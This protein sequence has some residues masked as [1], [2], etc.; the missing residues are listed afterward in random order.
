MNQTVPAAKIL[1]MPT[2]SNAGDS[3]APAGSPV[4]STEGNLAKAVAFLHASASTESQPVA[5]P[6]S[7]LRVVITPQT[8]FYRKYTEA[9]LRRYGAMALQKGR[10]PSLLGRELFRGKVTSYR[11]HGF[12]DVIIFVADVERCLKLLSPEQQ[13]LI[14]RVAVQEYTLAETASMLRWSMRSTQ[15]RYHEALDELTAIFQKRGL[16]QQVPGI[17][18]ALLKSCQEEETGGVAVS[19]AE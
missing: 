1:T 4:W 13:R 6:R 12:D 3:A 11:I 17:S 15:R 18:D 19:Y 8:A 14:V 2:R 9:M 7:P 5:V 16:M 10:V